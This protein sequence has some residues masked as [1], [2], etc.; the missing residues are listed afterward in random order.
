[1]PGGKDK[2]TQSYFLIFESKYREGVRPVDCNVKH[3]V[4]VDCSNGQTNECWKA[5]GGVHPFAHC[6]LCVCNKKDANGYVTTY[7]N[8]PT[9]AEAF[10]MDVPIL[11]QIVR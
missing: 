9:A 6:I 11:E 8:T 10:G 3:V 4:G 5:Y 2:R 7:E 1:M